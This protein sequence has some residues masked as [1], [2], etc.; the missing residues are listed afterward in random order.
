[1]KIFTARVLHDGWEMDNLLEVHKDTNSKVTL[2]TT[3]H[4]SDCE[5]TISALRCKIQETEKSLKG[6]KRALI[7]TN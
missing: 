4:G 1:M 3:N 2:R 5:M 7:L 6:L